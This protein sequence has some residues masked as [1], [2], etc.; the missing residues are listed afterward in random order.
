[1]IKD[2][3][4]AL[5]ESHIAPEGYLTDDDLNGIMDTVNNN[6]LK[7]SKP[8]NISYPS[9]AYACNGLF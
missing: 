2:H 4:D 8:S 5:I 3:I 7:K 1:M 9:K 6:L